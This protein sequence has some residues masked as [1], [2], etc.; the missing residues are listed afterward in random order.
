MSLKTAALRARI[1]TLGYTSAK[2][3]GLLTDDSPIQG[4]VQRI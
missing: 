1:T 4:S 2:A 3:M